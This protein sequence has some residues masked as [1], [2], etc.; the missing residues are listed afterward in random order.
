M[1]REHPAGLCLMVLAMVWG[2]GLGCGPA[3]EPDSGVAPPDGTAVLPEAEAVRPV[4]IVRTNDYS[5]GVVIDHEGN[6]YFSHERVITVVTPE[7][8]DRVWAENRRAQRP[9]DSRRRHPP[10]L[11]RHPSRRAASG[12]RRKHAGTGFHRMRGQAAGGDPTT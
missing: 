5:E 10:G 2:W 9:Q 6:I 4:E 8:E 7:G 11:R 1:I 3:G 12:C